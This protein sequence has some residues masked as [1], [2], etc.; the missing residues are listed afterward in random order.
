MQIG[1]KVGGHPCRSGSLSFLHPPQGL[2]GAGGA[3]RGSN[4]SVEGQLLKEIKSPPLPIPHVQAL[5]SCPATSQTRPRA[6]R[7][8]GL[9]P[10]RLRALPRAICLNCTSQGSGPPRV[11]AKRSDEAQEA[12]TGRQDHSGQMAPCRDCPWRGGRPG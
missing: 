7:K 6:P 12:H 2:A 4:V 5:G 1:L 9:N 10:A 3:A 8:E 11:R